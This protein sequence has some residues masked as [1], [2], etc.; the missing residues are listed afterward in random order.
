MP[1][2]TPVAGS[3]EAQAGRLAIEKVRR[4]PSGSLALGRRLKGRPTTALSEF[5]PVITGGPLAALAAGKV[6]PAAV[7]AAEL[8]VVE[9]EPE[10]AKFKLSAARVVEQS[11]S[12]AAQAMSQR[13]RVMVHEG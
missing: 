4:S 11:A 9:A 6:A 10:A 1:N 13:F 12:D 2:S 5:G 3:N 8:G 7:L